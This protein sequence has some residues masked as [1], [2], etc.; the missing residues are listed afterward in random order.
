MTSERGEFIAWRRGGRAA[1]RGA[2]AGDGRSR[3][4]AE[5]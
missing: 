3:Q 1:A 5:Q 2:C 4:H